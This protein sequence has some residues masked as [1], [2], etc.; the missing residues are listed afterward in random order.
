[1]KKYQQRP[2]YKFCGGPCQ[3]EKSVAE[4]AKDSTNDDGLQRWCKECRKARSLAKKKNL[5]D[6][7]IEKLDEKLLLAVAQAGRGGTTLPHQ[8]QALEVFL[9]MMG[10]I[11]G[12]MAYYAANLH[13]TRPG[14][15]ARTK[16]LNKIL[17]VIQDCSDDA[18]VSKPRHLMS[19]EELEASVNERLNKLKVITVEPDVRESA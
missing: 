12:F 13:A 16:I 14:S 5:L 17:S 9:Q 1:M 19:D 18:K 8:V 4:F 6:G 11:N 7:C 2:G 3:R 15:D 10:G